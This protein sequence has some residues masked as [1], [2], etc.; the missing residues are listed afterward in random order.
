MRL[1]NPYKIRNDLIKY[2]NRIL[3]IPIEDV[4]QEI[5]IA[6]ITVEYA[7]VYKESSKNVQRLLSEY[8]YSRKKG[9]DNFEPYY[10]DNESLPE[11]LYQVIDKIKYLYLDKGLSAKQ[12]AIIFDIPYSNKLQKALFNLFPK[13]LGWGGNRRKK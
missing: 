8:G 1:V 5:R 4:L 13:G 9:K 11:E 10:E 3:L 2:D 6:I 7:N 12:I